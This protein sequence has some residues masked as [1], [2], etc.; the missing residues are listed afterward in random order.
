MASSSFYLRGLQTG[1]NR[2]GFVTDM[3]GSFAPYQTLRV[4]A[5]LALDACV[6]A[7]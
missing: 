7:N 5:S 1:L 2:F 6:V 3:Q 4:N